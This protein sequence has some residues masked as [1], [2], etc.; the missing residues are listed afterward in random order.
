MKKG[1]NILMMVFAGIFAI[2]ITLVLY[3][4]ETPPFSL[5][6]AQATEAVGSAPQAAE[7]PASATEAPVT[8]GEQLVIVVP[9]TF[10]QTIDE[11]PETH[12][13]KEG[14]DTWTRTVTLINPSDKPVSVYLFVQGVDACTGAVSDNCVQFLPSVTVEQGGS[15]IVTI[16]FT[17]IALADNSPVEGKLILA[18][19]DI[20]REV[21]FSIKGKWQNTPFDYAQLGKW[22]MTALL[23]VIIFYIVYLLL[24]SKVFPFLRPE[25]SMP[26][27]MDITDDNKALWAIF[28]SRLMEMQEQGCGQS[29]TI[30]RPKGETIDL[31]TNLGKEGDVF[32]TVVDLLSWILPRRGISI[33]LQSMENQTKGRGLAAAL[34]QN[35]ND[36]I[37]AEHLFWAEEFG[38]G[39]QTSDIENILITPVILWISDWMEK[40]YPRKPAGEKPTWEVQAYCELARM[41]WSPDRD[42]GKKLYMEALFRDAANTQAQ[43]GLGRIWCEESQRDD[44]LKHEKEDCLNFAVSYLEEVCKNAPKHQDS[45]WFAAKYN[46]AVA[47]LYR[48]KK[49]VAREICDQLFD[50]INNPPP[51]VVG[52]K[53][54]EDFDRWLSKFK[55]MAVIFKQS[56]ILEK[57]SPK[58]QQILTELI[59]AAISEITTS[60]KIDFDPKK[61]LLVTLDYRSQYNAACYFSRCYRHASKFRNKELYAQTALDYLRL[62]LG[63]GGGLVSYAWE[64]QVLKPLRTDFK[65]EFEDIAPRKEAPK[66]EKQPDEAVLRLVVD[67]PIVIKSE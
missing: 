11:N 42:L 43:A 40:R 61:W 39:A 38:L 37:L 62:A 10:D 44:N 5:L 57:E 7:A 16:A 56:V 20:Q 24:Y 25:K 58:N 51:P 64:D 29:L 22:V 3:F 1:G 45:V 8:R 67:K 35:N 48:G 18:G 36:Q 49:V 19:G 33:R 6:K 53:K 26:L 27:R 55:S 47:Q 17:K 60:A 9:K 46:L 50:Q 12:T 54:D 23:G 13:P 31:P 2:A 15:Q 4:I 28:S 63:H 14:A 21:P 66:E 41:L 32:R 52:T 59:V 30:P 65:K 34:V